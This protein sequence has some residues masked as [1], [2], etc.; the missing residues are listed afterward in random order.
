M[1]GGGGLKRP[2]SKLGFRAIQEEEEEEDKWQW[3][4]KNNSKYLTTDMRPYSKE[5]CH[6]DDYV[7]VVSNFSVA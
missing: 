2:R 7:F 3:H 5:F 6:R 1:F 4:T